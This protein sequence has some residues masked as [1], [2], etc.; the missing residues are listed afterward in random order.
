MDTKIIK[1]LKKQ[2]QKDKDIRAYL[3]NQG[4]SKKD[5]EI[6]YLKLESKTIIALVFILI[7]LI[8]AS[9]MIRTP[10][11][12]PKTIN[13]IYN[14]PSKTY[15]FEDFKDPANWVEEENPDITIDIERASFLQST[16]NT[17]VVRL[18]YND[19]DLGF[20]YSGFYLNETFLRFYPFEGDKKISITD[21][22]VPNNGVMETF[23]S[24]HFDE[25]EKLIVKVFA[26][27]EFISKTK[28]T[29]VAYGRFNQHFIKLNFTEINN[30]IYYSQFYDDMTRYS[31]DF[32]RSYGYITYGNI[33][34]EQAYNRNY[35]N[36][37][38]VEIV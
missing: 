36:S 5:I 17:E 15:T 30:G 14:K 16:T 9:F 27:E 12:T 13:E 23:F 19:V 33:T 24:F 37:I 7:I 8:S 29:N 38:Y 10:H 18:Q 31:D 3:I 28:F 34:K 4:Y 1:D 2:G 35:T 22:I 6:A 21:K 20:D 11:Y 25:N 26:D 32:K